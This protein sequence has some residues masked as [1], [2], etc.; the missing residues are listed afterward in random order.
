MAPAMG[1][2]I[3]RF[4][5]L[6][7]RLKA[8]P[9]VSPRT[10]EERNERALYL[11]TALMGVPSGGIAAFFSVFLARLGAAPT[12]ISWATSAPALLLVFTV[13]PGAAIAERYAD[14]VKVRVLTARLIRVSFLFCALAP[15]V[16]PPAYLPLVLVAIWTLKTFPDAVAVPSWTAVMAQAI[17]PGKRARINGTRWALLSVVS[18]LSSAVFGWMLDLI[19]FPLNYQVVFFVSF[20][21]SSLDPYFFSFIKVPPLE[22]VARTATRGLVSRFAEYLRPVVHERNFLLFLACTVLYRIALNFPAA[23][24]S[25]FWVNDLN[26]SDTLIGLRGTV[27]NGVLVVAYMF[28]GH[29]ANRLG[30]R[31]VLWL[32][33]VGFAVYPIMTALSPSAVWLL[34]AAAVWG[35]TVAGLDMGIFD[36]MLASIPGKRQPLFAGA[37]S[38]VA[39]T[40]IFLGPLLGAALG[41]ATSTGTALIVAGILQVVTTIPFLFLPHDR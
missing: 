25:V 5:V 29:C 20:L 16:V 13:I 40:C 14:Q 38:M 41:Q 2:L 23:L 33:A 6:A 4:A 7:R 10:Q 8:S 32:S 28:W 9:V 27:G 18:A 31:K 22:E 39:N 26:A 12:L 1:L 17:S 3:H 19:A 15:F 36:L 21:L 34:P 30:H 35:I 24:F 11:S 37:Y